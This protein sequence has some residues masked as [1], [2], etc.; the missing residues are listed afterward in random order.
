MRTKDEPGRSRLELQALQGRKFWKK[1]LTVWFLTNSFCLVQ[2][3][4]REL[5]R[6][7]INLRDGQGNYPK[8]RL[9]ACVSL[10]T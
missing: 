9:N 5:C 8:T 2:I 4:I 6:L 10:S 3:R 1:R 7:I